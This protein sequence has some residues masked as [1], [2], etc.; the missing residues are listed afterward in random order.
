MQAFFSYQCMRPSASSACSLKLP[1]H[2]AFSFLCMRPSASSVC[3]LKLPWHAA[4]SY[5]CMRPRDTNAC[6]LT[7]LMHAAFRT[8]IPASMPKRGVSGGGWERGTQFTTQF[9][10]FTGTKIQ[11]LTPDPRRCRLLSLLLRKGHAEGYKEYAKVL[12]LLALLV[13][14]CKY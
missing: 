14:K 4:S 9:T 6:G 1:M 5:W 12:S 13:H 7:L 2:A 11:I 3:G 8:Y 10:C